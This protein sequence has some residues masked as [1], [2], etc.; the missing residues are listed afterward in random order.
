MRVGG[1][2]RYIDDTTNFILSYEA[3]LG[4]LRAKGDKK[5]IHDLLVFMSRL[6]LQVPD[7]Q[8]AQQ[9]AEEALEL[10]KEI[11]RKRRP[12]R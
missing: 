12:T 3:A 9:C 6:Y 8:K 2:Y 1:T 7:R 10:S 5:K 4:S 11:R